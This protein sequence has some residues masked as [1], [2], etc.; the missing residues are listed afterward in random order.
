MMLVHY[1]PNELYLFSE[2]LGGC[3]FDLNSARH[4]NSI[5]KFSNA[6]SVPG[7]GKLTLNVGEKS[8]DNESQYCKGNH[9]A[10]PAEFSLRKTGSR[11][12]LG[13][14]MT[15]HLIRHKMNCINWLFNP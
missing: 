4:Y 5:R 2:L 6:C 7:Q 13:M 3:W 12:P 1:G 8:C 15:G 11:S 10:R 14:H 9:I